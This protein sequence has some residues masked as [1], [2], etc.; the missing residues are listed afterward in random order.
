[1]YSMRHA[2]RI[3]SSSLR[4]KLINSAKGFEP[5]QTPARELK[6][7]NESYLQLSHIVQVTLKK[8]A[9]TIESSNSVMKVNI[10]TVLVRAATVLRV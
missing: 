7:T 2:R 4:R 5:T 3:G 6:V 10:C 8:K 9:S 1:M